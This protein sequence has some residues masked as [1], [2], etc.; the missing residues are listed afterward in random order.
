MLTL[1]TVRASLHPRVTR[2]VLI[3]VLWIPR[4]NLAP[5]IWKDLQLF[6][7][8]TRRALALPRGL[9]PEAERDSAK[10]GGPLPAT[11]KDLLDDIVLGGR[12]LRRERVSDEGREHLEPHSGQISGS[13]FQTFWMSRA[14]LGFL[15]LMNSLSSS[16][17]STVMTSGA[18][19]SPLS[20]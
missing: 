18:E 2:W 20:S 13:S 7:R 1:S 9:V 4:R 14:Q 5:L 16:S 8:S 17:S 19:L 3:F 6:R 10:T 15:T 11:A 12:G